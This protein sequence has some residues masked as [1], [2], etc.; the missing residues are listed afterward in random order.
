MYFSDFMTV[1]KFQ[2][3]RGQVGE[4][5]EDGKKGVKVNIILLFYS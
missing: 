1:F 3:L 2:G 4:N 5:G